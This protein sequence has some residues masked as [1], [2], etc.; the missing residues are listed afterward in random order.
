M[1]YKCWYCDKDCGNENRHGFS[2]EFDAP[3]CESCLNQLFAKPKNTLNREE[4][5]IR[6]EFEAEYDTIRRRM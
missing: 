3:I 6:D 2:F 1:N 5:V 4:A